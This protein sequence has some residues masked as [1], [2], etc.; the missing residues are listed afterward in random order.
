ME[1]KKHLYWTISLVLII[2]ILC[3]TLIWLNSHAWTIRFEMDH[4]TLEAVKS[5]NW[6][7]I[8]NG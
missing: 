7:N 2:T 6:S 4:N 8:I 3:G 5:I 1:D